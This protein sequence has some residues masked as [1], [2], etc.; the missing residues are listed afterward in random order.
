MEME[1]MRLLQQQQQQHRDNWKSTQGILKGG[2]APVPSNPIRGADSRQ[3]HQQE[4]SQSSHQQLMMQQQQIMMLQGQLRAFG[5]EQHLRSTG[6][7]REWEQQQIRRMSSSSLSNRNNSLNSMDF[8]P[9]ELLLEVKRRQSR[10]LSIT[11]ECG[12]IGGVGVGGEGGGGVGRGGVMNS[13]GASGMASLEGDANLVGITR[14]PSKNLLGGEEGG[15]GGIRGGGV[16]GAGSSPGIDRPLDNGTSS[17][18]NGGR[19]G[20]EAA[21]RRR[22]RL[23]PSS[24]RKSSSE[25]LLVDGERGGELG[26]IIITV[27]TA[28]PISKSTGRKRQYLRSSPVST[29]VTSDTPAEG[30]DDAKDTD[31][32]GNGNENEDGKR[33]RTK[34]PRQN[35]STS[36]EALLSAFD[37]LDREN[38]AESGG[39][40]KEED[41]NRS[42]S[43][44]ASSV[45]MTDG[46]DKRD[47]DPS[48]GEASHHPVGRDPPRGRTMGDPS[49]A[50]GTD[51][52][53]GPRHSQMAMIEMAMMQ[54]QL[55]MHE[56][57]LREQD[58]QL[59]LQHKALRVNA[60]RERIAW[61]SALGNSGGS[62]G[63]DPNIGHS[64]TSLLRSPGVMSSG[65]GGLGPIASGGGGPLASMYSP[66]LLSPDMIAML[67]WLQGLP[68]S[69]AVPSLSFHADRMPSA[70]P[71]PAR[72]TPAAAEPRPP[73]PEKI[74]PQEALQLFLDTFGDEAKKSCE[75]MLRAISETE[76][77]LVDIHAWDRSQ[78]LRK[79]HS[80]TVVKT[81]RSRASV[82]AFLMG[83][84]PP[85][86]PNKKRKRKK[87]LKQDNLEDFEE[88]DLQ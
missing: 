80:R 1:E 27:P 26:N 78:G 29:I 13:S 82:K 38:N 65:I 46:R 33:P 84:D 43:S 24:T 14:T 77:S 41:D 35:S 20:G 74:I 34:R 64:L 23:L 76:K 69:Q 11:D 19:G 54:E 31:K 50:P 81:R 6:G 44:F 36:F 75:D 72:D 18:A 55:V 51:T 40:V 28:D 21:V 16:G 60:L 86:E 25:G 57:A 22:G 39:A 10:S 58:D 63:V 83:I 15:G 3:P 79:C 68:S 2:Y 37:V 53:A 17:T 32:D 73:S 59:K 30:G 5:R 67:G 88:E 85:R 56:R 7:Q 9:E 61:A 71:P 62:A 66:S 8:T 87:K 4:H 12:V 49:A 70:I 42:S 48:H 52:H 45:E 47:V